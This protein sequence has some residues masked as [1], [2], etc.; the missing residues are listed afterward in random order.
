[1]H[2]VAYALARLPQKHWRQQ[3]QEGRSVWS[4]FHLKTNLRVKASWV[5]ARSR[6]AR[7]FGRSIAGRSHAESSSPSCILR[8]FS[9]P[10]PALLC[11]P[12]QP[13]LSSSASGA[14]P[15]DAQLHFVCCILKTY[16][17]LVLSVPSRELT[18][19]T[20]H[21][22]LGACQAVDAFVLPSR[23]EGW[24]RPVMEAMAMALPVIATN[25][26][27]TTA[28][29]SDETSFPLDFELA[30]APGLQGRAARRSAL[31][32][33][34]HV[35]V[36]KEYVL[37]ESGRHLTQAYG[38]LSRTGMMKHVNLRKWMPGRSEL[39]ADHSR[40]AAKRYGRS[41]L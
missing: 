32:V 16:S 27:G 19:H 21:L 40:E 6:A 20:S 24:G 17:T 10:R 23:G 18:G 33:K 34:F 15:I 13:C 38:V 14:S 41:R 3:Q 35:T 12:F 30:D 31:N 4:R 7:C 26:S 25:W 37:G 39:S 11:T 8:S 1:M 22:A 29:L 9:K 36:A 2:T 5:S 28:M